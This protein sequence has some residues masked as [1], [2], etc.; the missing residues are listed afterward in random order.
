[1]QAKGR[2]RFPCLRQYSLATPDLTYISQS[3]VLQRELVQAKASN[4]TPRLSVSCSSSFAPFKAPLM[5]ASLIDPKFARRSKSIV[6][7]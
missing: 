5:P 7:L 4:R 2:A 3:D 6:P 1:M